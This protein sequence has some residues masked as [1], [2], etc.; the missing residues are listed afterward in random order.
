MATVAIVE[1][2]R[3][4]PDVLRRWVHER[5]TT[6]FQGA[7]GDFV[8]RMAPAAG[9]ARSVEEVRELWEGVIGPTLT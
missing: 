4:A 2:L 3:D 6:L 1:E 7:P 9:S 8:A 5:L